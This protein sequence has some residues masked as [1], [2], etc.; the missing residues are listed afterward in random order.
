MHYGLC[1]DQLNI[2]KCSWAA[3]LDK[4]RAL[5]EKAYRDNAQA[6][7]FEGAEH[8][9]GRR[10]PLD[11]TIIDPAV[12]KITGRGFTRRPGSTSR[13]VSHERRGPPALLSLRWAMTTV[14]MS[15]RLAPTN[16]QLHR[17]RRPALPVRRRTPSGRDFG[18][19]W[20]LT[21]IAGHLS[22]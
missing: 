7:N 2:V 14:M 8:M 10:R 21:P 4:R 16:A 13:L 5:L 3:R 6:P 9:L 12:L 20:R 19:G 11:G 15:A 17:Q 1:Y 18:S 22:F